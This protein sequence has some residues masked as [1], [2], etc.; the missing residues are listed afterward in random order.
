MLCEFWGLFGYPTKNG[1]KIWILRDRG[2]GFFE[3]PE[4]VHFWKSQFQNLFQNSDFWNFAAIF[5]YIQYM[6]GT[7]FV[8]N[9]ISKR[10][11]K[12]FFLR[13]KGPRST[14][15]TNQTISILICSR[16]DDS[17]L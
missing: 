10:R 9:G 5:V 11:A 14:Y 13:L 12:K 6:N 15:T 8:E 7:D 1:G 3:R 17:L 4:K 2:K 16:I